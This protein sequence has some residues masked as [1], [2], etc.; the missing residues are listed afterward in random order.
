[1]QVRSDKEN[2]DGSGTEGRKAIVCASSKGLGRACA[3]HLAEA[4]V[5][6]V[7]N[8]RSAGP[9]RET[10]EQIRAAFGVKVTPVAAD[11]T[12]EAG[13]EEIF[14]AC[15]APDILVNNA[16]GP[17]AGDFRD[18]SRADWHMALD[19]NMLAPIEMIRRC[20][21]GMIARKFGRIVNITSAGGEIAL[22]AA[23]P[24]Q[25]GAHRPDRVYCRHCPGRGGP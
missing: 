21:D 8:A 17:P 24:V 12:T 5:D 19:G 14:A 20:L 3:E 4:G 16:A 23:R 25:R 7:L 2:Y 11:V 1:M 6:L 13:Q 22:Q 10:A 15:P 18:W 9:L